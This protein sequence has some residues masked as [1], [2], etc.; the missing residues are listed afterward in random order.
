VGAPAGHAVWVKL[1]NL[2]FGH[3]WFQIKKVKFDDDNEMI[4]HLKCVR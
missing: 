4:L 2:A 1:H 3:Y